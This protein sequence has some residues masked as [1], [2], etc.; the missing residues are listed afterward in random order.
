MELLKSLEAEKAI[1]G[2]VLFEEGSQLEVLHLL[3]E[4]YFTDYTCK[5]AL[6]AIFALERQNKRIDLVT[7][8]EELKAM[9]S[10]VGA[11]ELASLTDNVTTI[12]NLK[13][14]LQI[15]IG[16][17][18][19]RQIFQLGVNAQKLGMSNASAAI[20][21]VSSISKEIDLIMDMKGEN[22]MS[23]LGDLAIEHSE[24]TEKIKTGEAISGFKMKL[25]KVNKLQQFERGDLV[26]LAG[27]PA[28]GKTASAIQWGLDFSECDYKVALFSLEMPKRQLSNR[29]VAN[30]SEIH[31]EQI[32]N[33]SFG[34]GQNAKYVNALAEISSLPFWID[35]TASLN[36]IELKTKL[37]K[38]KKKQGGLDIVVV[39]YLQLMSSGEKQGN[40]EQEIAYISRQLKLIAKELDV[41]MVA[42]SQLSRA[43][44]S[45]G[46]DKRPMLS[47]LRESGAIEQDADVV[48]FNYRPEY[49]GITE[50]EEGNNCADVI[51]FIFAKTET[52]RLALQGKDATLQSKRFLI[53]RKLACPICQGKPLK[54]RTGQ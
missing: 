4:E 6:K 49:Y 17:W 15:V 54:L 3:K 48:I 16:H 25:N 38:L 1:V 8:N 34:A 12:N 30:K 35:D 32:K 19:K 39:D 10:N 46:G 43:V 18:Q 47:D 24:L 26:I 9:D 21:D 7:V 11:F 40:R 5:E 29:I 2:A 53:L 27:R 52:G 45:R 42:L 13:S 44:E 31:L 36:P 23:S 20:D 22:E 33:A 28:M 14:Y 51:E 37:R 41:L 50:D